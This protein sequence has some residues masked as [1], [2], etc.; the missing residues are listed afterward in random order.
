MMG[1]MKFKW[2]RELLDL[3]DDARR[4]RNSQSLTCSKNRLAC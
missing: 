1:V 3:V 2:A 4:P